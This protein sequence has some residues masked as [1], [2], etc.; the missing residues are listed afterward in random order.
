M[1]VKRG[2][3]IPRAHACEGVERPEQLIVKFYVTIKQ[4][5][6]SPSVSGIDKGAVKGAVK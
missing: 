5:F 2:K 3:K 1:A 4:T 6:T